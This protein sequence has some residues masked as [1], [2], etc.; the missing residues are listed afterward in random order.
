MLHSVTR[1]SQVWLLPPFVARRATVWVSEKQKI[2]FKRMCCDT[3]ND[4]VPIH[5]CNYVFINHENKK[6]MQ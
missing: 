6:V 4:G 2:D 5:V 3:Y 1:I